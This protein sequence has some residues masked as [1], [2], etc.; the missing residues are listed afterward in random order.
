MWVEISSDITYTS[1]STQSSSSWGC[2]LKY[3]S[4]INKSDSC[5]HPLRE[6]VSWNVYNIIN[7]FL[8]PVILFVRMWV[9]I[10]CFTLPNRPL[11]R[12]PLREDVSWNICSSVKSSKQTVVILFVRMWVEIP[13]VRA[14]MLKA[15][16]IL[17]VRMWVEIFCSRTSSFYGWS[18][19]SW[20][21]ELKYHYAIFVPTNNTVILFVRMWVEILFV[22]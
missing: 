15:V 2:E 7:Y 3:L 16:V 19:S 4:L 20:G 21:C 18:S 11:L 10:F 17:F 14:K 6:D 8:S 9:E 5:G 22:P 13:E 12:H 1:N